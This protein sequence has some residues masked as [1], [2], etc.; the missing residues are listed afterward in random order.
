[1]SWGL[2]ESNHHNSQPDSVLIR[3]TQRG[4]AI[5]RNNEFGGIVH[6]VTVSRKHT[7]LT[8]TEG[9]VQVTDMG[10][11]AGTFIE[12]QDEISLVQNSR[13]VLKVG[14]VA[15]EVK[16]QRDGRRKKQD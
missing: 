14:T 16:L 3:L 5:G 9:Q 7:M 15:I 10:S 8:Y 2:F 12:L 6:D 4:I 11:L 13:I 1:M